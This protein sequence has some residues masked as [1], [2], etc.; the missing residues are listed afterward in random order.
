MIAATTVA[1][2][3]AVYLIEHG[4]CLTRISVAAFGATCGAFTAEDTEIWLAKV[5][6][7]VAHETK[8]F[9]AGQRLKVLLSE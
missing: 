2:R 7:R 4:G 3:A 5:S 1:D 9:H 8:L 6:E